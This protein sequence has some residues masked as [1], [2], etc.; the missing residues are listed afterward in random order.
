MR[1]VAL[2]HGSGQSGMVSFRFTPLPLVLCLYGCGVLLGLGNGLGWLGLLVVA[3][4]SGRGKVRLFLGLTLLAGLGAGWGEHRLEAFLRRPPEGAV[5]IQGVVEGVESGQVRLVLPGSSRIDLVLPF[6]W[7]AVHLKEGDVLVAAARWSPVGAALNPGSDHPVRRLRSQGVRARAQASNR[8][9]RLH[10]EDPDDIGRLIGAHVMARRVHDRFPETVV[11]WVMAMVFGDRTSLPPEDL[12]A[13][14]GSGLAH[15][16]AVSGLHVGI[17]FGAVLL[18]TVSVTSRLPGSGAWRTAVSGIILTTIAWMYGTVLGWPASA[19]RALLM[20]LLA[21]VFRQSGRPGWLSRTWSWALLSFLALRPEGLIHDL[22]TQLSFAAVGG[23]CGAHFLVPVRLRGFARALA[24]SLAAGT[25]AFLATTPLLLYTIGWVPLGSILTG[26]VGIPLT[27]AFLLLVLSALLLPVGGHGLAA[28]AS[29]FLDLLLGWAHWSASSWHP[30]LLA[31]TNG[32]MWW[33][34]I[35]ACVLVGSLPK[36]SRVLRIV[37]AL[38]LLGVGPRVFPPDRLIITLLDVGQGEAI[39]LEGAGPDI[40]VVDSGPGPRAGTTIDHYLGFR[41]AQN[42]DI[43]LSHADRDHT[44]GLER[45]LEQRPSARVHAPWPDDVFSGEPLLA[46]DRRALAQNVRL[47][48]LHPEAEGKDNDHSAVL[49]LVLPGL[50]VLLTGDI[51][52]STETFLVRE[53]EALWEGYPVRVLKAA[54]HGS[55]TSSGAILL[56]SY[57]PDVILLSAGRDN[58]FGHPHSDVVDRF[59]SASIPWFGTLGA[60]ALQLR[61]DGRSTS[62]HRWND[63]SWNR[64]IRMPVR[65]AAAVSA[66]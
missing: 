21:W 52:S 31:S 17:L 36:G 3:A 63:G 32:W 65:P 35:S 29:L 8:L 4:G 55:S 22:G 27:T 12:Q 66:R 5:L 2:R 50:R 54:H 26:L 10:G 48:V 62:V 53:W 30:V 13:F 14:R 51:S 39:V 44:G 18:L 1:W 57:A 23:L 11:P 9:I 34:V 61:W 58:P 40:H 24:G 6:G 15:L 42:V 41:H 28:A 64:I 20:L 46:G 59:E 16:L 19:S 38:L 25:T 60:G 7:A 33:S 37:T 56:E 45:L 49:L 47:L 43:W